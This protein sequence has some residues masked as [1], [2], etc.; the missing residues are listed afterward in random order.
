MFTLVTV[1]KISHLSIFW[2]FIV[3]H[4]FTSLSQGPGQIIAVT[5]QSYNLGIRDLECIMITHFFINTLS[6]QNTLLNKH[7]VLS[8]HAIPKFSGGLILTSSSFAFFMFVSTITW[9]PLN[10][11][12]SNFH[13]RSVGGIPR[14]LSKMGIIG[15]CVSWL[16]AKNILFSTENPTMKNTQRD[17]LLVSAHKHSI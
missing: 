6:C 10:G 14:T 9:E 5:I 8:K 7:I 4:I 17:Q 11:S 2:W 1:K 15:P 13:T 3:N 16:S 12:R